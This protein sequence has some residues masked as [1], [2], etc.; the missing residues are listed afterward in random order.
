MKSSDH[1]QTWSGPTLLFSKPGSFTRHP[2][3]VLKDGTWLL[4][5]TYVTSFGIGKGA[6]TNYSSVE[7]SKDGG[8]TWTECLIDGSAGKVQPTAVHYRKEGLVV[9]YRDRA[10]DHIYRS[11]SEDGCHW[12]TPA[13]TVLPN[14]NASVQAFQ[15]KNGHTVIAFDNSA[16]NRSGPTP[17]GGLRKP[18]SVA[19]SEDGGATWS[20]VRDIEIGRPGYGA[21]EGAI[22]QPGREE[23]SYP[24]ILQLSDGRLMI[25]YTY[26]RQMIKVVTFSE[27]WVT[28][29]TSVGLF[30]R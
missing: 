18:L 12:S 22:K 14:N 1:G 23:Y 13:A 20:A 26:R 10:S 17:V 27:S 16:A 3:L 25:A 8:N 29:G 5:L 19:L 21:A 6:E 30:H 9:F 7:L 15:L 28:A 2:L 11:T 4:P 24:S